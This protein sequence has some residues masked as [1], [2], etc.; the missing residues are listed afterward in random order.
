MYDV[1]FKKSALD[2]ALDAT[3]KSL[4]D[5]QLDPWVG[6][7]HDAIPPPSGFYHS[8][9]LME[10][11]SLFRGEPVIGK[12][13]PGHGFPHRIFDLYFV[14]RSD[15]VDAETNAIRGRNLHYRRQRQ[16]GGVA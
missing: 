14:E 7:L 4:F 13:I 6:P 12:E 5:S 3:F 1:Y 8:E 10:F 11:Q 16:C 9:F 15:H 2:S